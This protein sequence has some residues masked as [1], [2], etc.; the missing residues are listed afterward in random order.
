MQH[1]VALIPENR[2]EEGVH[3]ILSVLENLAAATVDKRKNLGFIK[4]KEESKT[5]GQMIDRLSIKISSPRQLVQSLSGGNM[6][7]VVL[8]KWLIFE[9]QVI[10]LLEPT[11]GVDVATKQQIYLLIRQLADQ[12]VAVVLNTSDML[13]LIGLCDRV[14]IMNQGFI[15]ARLEGEQITEENIMKASVS[16]VDILEAEKV[17]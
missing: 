15:T 2:N 6:Q 12:G 14:L 13:E 16:Q 4:K 9:P 10:V 7:K 8:G 11:K 5:T 1:G 17:P 3:L